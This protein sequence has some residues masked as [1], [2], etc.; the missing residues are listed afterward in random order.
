MWLIS[1]LFDFT[2][3]NFILFLLKFF[4]IKLIIYNREYLDNL[5]IIYQNNIYLYIIGIVISI[6][7]F[8][9]YIYL[10]YYFFLK[11][12]KLKEIEGLFKKYNIS[13]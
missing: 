13:K 4:F 12:L 2:L 5:F 11:E 8:L 3:L 6:L 9:I 7:F 1:F 10:I